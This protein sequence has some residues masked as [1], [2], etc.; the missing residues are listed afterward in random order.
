MIREEQILLAGIGNPNEISGSSFALGTPTGLTLTTQTTGGTLPATT[1]Y[2][3]RVVALS[4]DGTTRVLPLTTAIPNTVA[5]VNI[6]GTTSTFNGGFSQASAEGT[7]T[8]G[9]GSTN[10]ITASC[11]AV[12]NAYAYLWVM[13]TATGG[14]YVQV[15]VTN[16][17][18]VVLTNTGSGNAN[19]PAAVLTADYSGNSLFFDGIWTQSLKLLSAYVN[20]ASISVSNPYFTGTATMIN[21]TSPYFVGMYTSLNGAN[22][23]SNTGGGVNELDAWFQT[24][25]DLYKFSPSELYLHASL[26][27]ALNTI[28]INNGG[29]PLV[30]YMSDL[31]DSS[32]RQGF[33]ANQVLGR[34]MNPITGDLVNI[35]P[36]PYL[37]PGRILSYTE[38]LPYPLNE[39]GNLC[40]VQARKDY[41]AE[42]WPLRTRRYEYGVYSE[43]MA[44]CYFPPGFSCLDNI[45]T[46]TF[47]PSTVMPLQ[48]G[49]A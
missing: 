17:N 3:L 27:R 10:Q 2:F 41:Y 14:P 40:A 36:H 24:M 15:A 22:L 42:E 11:A 1:A 37:T 32:A 20:P 48:T 9:S 33:T 44:K 25:Y 26:L 23:T 30:R 12:P 21:Q 38:K 4:M 19:L 43:Q 39:T 8:T 29:A 35:L 47:I 31:G 6:D 7:V 13:G 49:A 5:R 16:T 45:G 34:Y 28:V 46:P 18:A